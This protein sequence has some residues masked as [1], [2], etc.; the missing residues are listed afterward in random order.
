MSV[1]QGRRRYGSSGVIGAPLDRVDGRLKVTGAAT[2][3]AEHK[4]AGLAYAAQAVTTIARGRIARLDASAAEAAPGVLAVITHLNAPTFPTLTGFLTGQGAAN[5]TVLPL[6][7]DRIH[8]AGQCVAVVVAE[9]PEQAQEAARLVQVEYEA[10]TPRA[11]IE[12]H[13]DEAYPPAPFYGGVPPDAVRG[14]V[15][16]GLAEAAVRVEQTYSTPIEH[17]NP[18][19]PH[20]TIAAWDADGSLTVYDASQGVMLTRQGLAEAFELPPAKVRVICPFVGG[21][22]GTKG[23]LWPYTILAAVAAQRVGRPVKLVLTRAQMFTSTGYRSQTIQDVK[24]GARADGTLTAIVHQSTSIGSAVGEFPEIAPFV[25]KMLYACP[26]LETSIRLV[27]LD[28]GVPFAMRGP[29]EA[30][31]LFALESALDELAYKLG[32]DPIELRLKNFA[33]TDPE[34]GSPWT[35]NGLRECYAQGA[36][37]FGW[38]RRTPQ[39]RS[40]RDG[41]WLV[42]M[43]MATASYPTVGFP[44]QAKA[45]IRADGSALVQSA[46]A[47]IGTGQYTV[48]TQVAAEALGLPPDRVTFELGDTTQPFA[49]VAGGSSGVR[50]VGP[51]V[52]LASETARQKVLDLATADEESPLGGYGP[53]LV[54]AEAGELFVRHDP[55]RRESYAA[56]LSRHNLQAVTGDGAV[57]MAMNPG[58]R[59]V[60]AFGAQFVEVR[61]DPDFGL[62]RVTRA[63]GAFDIGRVMN[64]KTARSQGIGGIVMGIGMALLEH[65]VVHPTLGTFVSPDLA[66]YLLPVHADVPAI[67]AFF[68]EVEDPYVNSLGAKGVGEIGITGVAA[69][70]ANAV[71]HA[72]GIRVR[73]LPITPESLLGG[74]QER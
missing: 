27:R 8:H 21:G 30:S 32:L 28:L 59:R 4:L 11:E 19:E 20:A 46:T 12:H 57:E 52:K 22:F 25:T 13:L 70:I 61:V 9:T 60:N 40:M 74:V 68:V 66:G 7:D 53:E 69:A 67:D 44:A 24:L 35:S 56:I 23:G 38:A 72:T 45:T 29:G 34:T 3:A 62:V 39:P 54:G 26:N 58:G 49:F 2:Y 41:R 5:Q 65:S 6:R 18:M 63:L 31:G 64:Q 33:E 48:M 15:S 16:Q 47:D 42:G 17:H 71:Y 36:E 73:D 37:R 1:E 10:E 55:T 14:D 50:S 51:A 43:G